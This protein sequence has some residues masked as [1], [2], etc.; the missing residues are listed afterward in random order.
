M[1]E[2]KI[3]VE[4]MHCHSCEMLIIDEI[5]EMK[6]VK[7]VEASHKDGVV[8]VKYDG[9]IDVIQIKKAIISLGYKVKD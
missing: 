5:G 8:K 7:A 2:L 3:N 1:D 4:G 9:G 6:G